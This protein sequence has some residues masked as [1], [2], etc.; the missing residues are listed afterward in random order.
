MLI[1]LVSLK[2][3]L[4]QIS[5]YRTSFF[6]EGNLKKLIIM[7]IYTGEFI[8][9]IL[10]KIKKQDNREKYNTIS[11][12]AE[13]H[14][15]TMDYETMRFPRNCCC[16]CPIPLENIFGAAVIYDTLFILFENYILHILYREG[17]HDVLLLKSREDILDSL[18]VG[19][20]HQ[21]DGSLN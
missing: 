3:F 2:S 9:G 16:C 1:V 5:A 6:Q 12:F 10:K 18:K 7:E 15:I 4:N 8:E 13:V 11:P 19:F 17:M 20:T 14:G 21:F